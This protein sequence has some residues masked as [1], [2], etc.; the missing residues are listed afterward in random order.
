MTPLQVTA[1]VPGQIALPWGG[2]ALDTLLTWSR[3]QE[4]DLAP[5]RDASECQPVEIPLQLELGG[6]FY[7]CSD[8]VQIMQDFDLR[9][10]NRR[11]PI[12]QYQ[13]MGPATGRVQITAG[14]DKSYRIPLEVGHLRDERM[15][16]FAIGNVPEVQRLLSLVGYLGKKRSV[17]LGKVE[18]WEVVALPDRETWPGFPVALDGKPLRPLPLDW[19]GLDAPA[20]AYATLSIPRWD[21]SRE[22]L[23]A[24]PARHH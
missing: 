6:R 20:Q 10:T 9:Y 5:P 12:E 22:E 2:V 14:V 21:H 11:A 15:D 16:W 7:M 13:S 24:V 4:L 18:R 8:S 3:A 19:P 17:G 1:R 23:C